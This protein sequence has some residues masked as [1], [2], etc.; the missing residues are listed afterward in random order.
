MI[1]DVFSTFITDPLYNGLIFLIST[2][3]FADVG[4]AVI[5]LTTVVKIIL[6]PLAH[7]SIKTQAIVRKIDPEMKE[8]REKYKKDRQEQARQTMDLYKKYGINPLSGLLLII[9]QIPI[10]LGLYLVFLKGG[11]PEINPERLYSFITSPEIVNMNFLSLID[12]GGRSLI[13]ALIAGVAQFV[14]VRL[15]LP[16]VTRTENPTLKEDLMHSFNIQMRYVLPVI[17]A[18]IAYFISAAVALYWATSNLFAI[19]QEIFVRRKIIEKMDI[20]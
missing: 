9:I 1:V 13:L 11:L 3:P 17:V 2:V 15:S 6:L 20:N 5:I 16:K 8:I 7:K 10:I 19:G 4:V 18:L 12:M 14:Q